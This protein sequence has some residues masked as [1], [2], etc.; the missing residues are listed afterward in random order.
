MDAPLLELKRCAFSW[1]RE[2]KPVFTDASMAV[3]PGSWNVLSGSS[4]SGKSTLAMMCAGLL[5]PTRGQ[6]RYGLGRRPK[7]RTIQYLFQD[8]FAAIDPLMTVGEWLRRVVLNP[9]IAQQTRP[10]TLGGQRSA[11]DLD[12]LLDRLRLSKLLLESRPLDLS[13]GECQRVNLVAALLAAPTFLILD[14]PFTMVDREASRLMFDEVCRLMARE[15]TAVLLIHH[16]ELPPE[17]HDHQRI[18]I[19]D[20]TVHAKRR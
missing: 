20:G 6:I 8:P 18:E 4:G 11:D 14:E 16:G 3:S 9:R 15:H 12:A 10:S 19:K 2:S 17:V 7:P 5:Q 13:G 1:N